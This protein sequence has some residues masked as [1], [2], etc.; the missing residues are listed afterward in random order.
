MLL[1]SKQPITPIELY[2]VNLDR[3]I[4]VEGGITLYDIGTQL[5]DELGFEPIVACVNNKNEGLYY[6]VYGP[7]KVEFL[8][9]ES[10]VGRRV[11]THSLCMM[12]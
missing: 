6:Q 4:E 2:I 7:K 9:K 3:T 8:S 12:L 1:K 10:S 5:S 11:Y